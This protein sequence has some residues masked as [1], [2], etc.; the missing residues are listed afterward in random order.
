MVSKTSVFCVLKTFCVDQVVYMGVKYFFHLLNYNE[1]HI[2][3]FNYWLLIYKNNN[4]DLSHFSKLVNLKHFGRHV[5]KEF[6]LTFLCVSLRKTKHYWPKKHS[7]W[8]VFLK[9]FTKPEIAFSAKKTHFH[10][11]GKILFH[12]NR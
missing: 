3:G 2:I 7:L 4:L 5:S 10:P 11:S 9:F 12:H 6:D 1:G 8:L